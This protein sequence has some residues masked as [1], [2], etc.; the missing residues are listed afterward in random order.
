MARLFCRRRIVRLMMTTAVQMTTNIAMLPANIPSVVSL[1]R[2][3]EPVWI[4][5]APIQ[6]SHRTLSST[7]INQSCQ[8]YRVCRLLLYIV[9]VTH[10][11]LQKILISFGLHIVY[12]YISGLSIL[13]LFNSVLDC[14]SLSYGPIIHMFLLF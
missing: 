2:I 7:S 11:K 14:L 4:G 13:F 9:S 5:S 10:F 1:M 6:T 3:L 8:R 12:I